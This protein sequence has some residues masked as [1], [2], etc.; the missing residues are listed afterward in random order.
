[1]ETPSEGETC[2]GHSLAQQERGREE[3]EKPELGLL[4]Q[5]DLD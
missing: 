1:M 3:R 2:W 5:A 4:H